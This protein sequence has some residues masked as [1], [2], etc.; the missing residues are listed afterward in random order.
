LIAVDTSVVVAAFASWHEAHA[1]AARLLDRR[2]R[3]PAHALIESYSVLTRLPAPHRAD[4]A[5]VAE[6]LAERFPLPPLVLPARAHAAFVA[7]LTHARLAGG[8]AYDALIA[9]TAKRARAVLHTR[10]RRAVP[11]YERFGV[12]FELLG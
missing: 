3:L 4:P 1:Q 5:I 2:P 7:Q 9:A 10:D 8:A 12:R 6:F 11:T